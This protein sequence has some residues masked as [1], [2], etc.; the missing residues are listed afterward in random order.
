MTFAHIVVKAE[1]GANMS[2]EVQLLK[3][4]IKKLQNKL[5]AVQKELRECKEKLKA[6]QTPEIVEKTRTIHVKCPKQDREIK[7]LRRKLE[8]VKNPASPQ[9]TITRRYHR[10][11]PETKAKLSRALA[12]IDKLKR[13]LKAG[14]N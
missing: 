5:F 11:T 3:H 9:K 13:E 6:R 10:D 14:A 2:Q 4:D 1:K 12:E 8:T 7:E